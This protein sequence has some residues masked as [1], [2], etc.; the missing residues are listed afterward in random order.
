MSWYNS[1]ILERY[2]LFDLVE[3][4]SVDCLPINY[5]K[6]QRMKQ[7]MR[8]ATKEFNRQSNVK[9]KKS[10]SSFGCA[11]ESKCLNM[12]NGF[13]WQPNG[14]KFCSTNYLSVD[15][16]GHRCESMNFYKP[17]SCTHVVMYRM[18]TGEYRWELLN[19]NAKRK[20]ANEIDQQVIRIIDFKHFDYQV[21][22]GNNNRKIRGQNKRIQTRQR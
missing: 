2:E 20:C 17:G 9:I 18:R 10:L 21:R 7:K 14:N 4:P 11:G 13:P 3:N 5:S 12:K 15:T 6:E 16:A 19:V 8:N 1:F 22:N